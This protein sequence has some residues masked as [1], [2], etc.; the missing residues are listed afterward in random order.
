MEDD[1]FINR[2]SFHGISIN[3]TQMINV[4]EAIKLIL[5]NCNQSRIETVTLLE[6]NGCILAE[7]IISPIDSP[8]FHQS[9]VDGYAFSYD[10]RNKK[11]ELFIKGEIQAGDF[12]NLIL[13]PAETLRIFTGA[14]IPNGSDTV[15]MQEKIEIT[16]NKIIINDEHLLK[17]NNV[18][19]QGSQIKQGETALKQGQL[20]MPP[21]ISYLSG[22]GIAHVKIFSKPTIS[23]LATGK[24]LIKAG[25]ELTKGKIFESNAIG[26]E[27]ALQQINIKPVSVEIVDD[28][29]EEL[30]NAIK[31]QLNSDIL[32]LTGGVSVGDYDLVPAVLEKCGVKKIFH[33]VKQKPGKP[34]YFGKYNQTLIFALPGNP[35]AVMSCFYEYVVDAISTF[36]KKEYFKKTLLPLA[37]DYNKKSGLTFF[38]KGKTGEQRVIILENQESY[39]LNSFAVADCLVELEEEKEVFKKGDLVK[40][41]TI[42]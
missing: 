16:G 13:N 25:Q 26:L 30:M 37:E 9:A 22:L 12:S 21:A 40:I 3:A 31:H 10:N 17:G 6:A 39:M 19:L 15:V 4:T 27:S 8:P 23:I 2:Y 35:A 38:L 7:N 20:L 42:F 14:P 1:F 28:S 24:E 36:T 33:K 32:I 29:E 41:K 34:F 18:R 11:N 5:E